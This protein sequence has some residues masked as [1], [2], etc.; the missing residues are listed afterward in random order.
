MLGVVLLG[1]VGGVLDPEPPDDMTLDV[2]T[3]DVAGVGAASAASAAS[4]TPPALPRPPTCTCAFT[5]TG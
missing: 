1:D 2:E 4:L 3:E 5:T